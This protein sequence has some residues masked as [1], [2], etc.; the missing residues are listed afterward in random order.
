MQK[1]L[2][3][4]I[5]YALIVGPGGY[6]LSFIFAWMLAQIPKIPRTIIAILIYLPSMTSGVMMST[7]WSIIFFW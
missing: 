7:I 3:N 1:V 5:K 2:P 4:T 6:I